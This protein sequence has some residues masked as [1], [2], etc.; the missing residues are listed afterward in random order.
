MQVAGI[1]AAVYSAVAATSST[2][3]GGL[4]EV[5]VDVAG[6]DP[7]HWNWANRLNTTELTTNWQLNRTKTP[8]TGLVSVT[9]VGVSDTSAMDLVFNPIPAEL[10]TNASIGYPI[11]FLI[12]NA[13][14]ITGLSTGIMYTGCVTALT[15]S[16]SQVT[17][18]VRLRNMRYQ[19]W[20]NI[21]GTDANPSRFSVYPG[22]RDVAHDPHQ[23]NNLVMQYRNSTGI[24]RAM[25]FGSND[26][27]PTANRAV[28]VGI[29][30]IAD[31]ND[32]LVIGTDN[33][34]NKGRIRAGGLSMSG[35]IGTWGIIPVSGNP[36]GSVTSGV[37]LAINPNGGVGST[38]WVKRTT[39][40][41][42]GWFNL[43]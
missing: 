20:Q 11:T 32:E 12:K 38:L 8:L 26:F 24:V 36:E 10:A 42:T 34:F 33:V 6:L 30:L 19:F 9:A 39:S 41:N 27:T 16:G 5:Q 18:R 28:A 21:G 29:G 31:T 15:Y 22:I 40:G 1:Q 37:A 7:I 13:S 3:V 14:S 23:M 25:S 17:A 43:A 4:W 2:L 35:A